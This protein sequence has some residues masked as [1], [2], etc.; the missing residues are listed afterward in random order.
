[1]R[2]AIAARDVLV[3]HPFEDYAGSVVRFLRGGGKRCRRLN[4]SLSATF[5]A[6]ARGL[7]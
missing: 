5:T 1:M 7:I 4:H 3:H 6:A 2:E